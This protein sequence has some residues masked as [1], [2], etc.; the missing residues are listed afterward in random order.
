M[1]TNLG[2]V[3]KRTI[4]R[5]L[6]LYW[7]NTLSKFV[8]KNRK[9]NNLLDSK[10]EHLWNDN[11]DVFTLYYASQ[12]NIASALNVFQ[13]PN[14]KITSF[15]GFINKRKEKVPSYDSIVHDE[16]S[17]SSTNDIEYWLTEYKQVYNPYRM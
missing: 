8:W 11:W 3:N 1:Q 2:A 4:I 15:L 5:S 17:S 13:Y 7:A 14:Y 9:K 16:N 6:K 12:K 10:E